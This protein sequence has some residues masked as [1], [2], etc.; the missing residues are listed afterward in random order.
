MI[1]ALCI[2]DL[3]F[4]AE[5]AARLKHVKKNR[6]DRIV[7]ALVRKVLVF[8]PNMDSIPEN[9]ETNPPPRPA[10]IRIIMISNAQAMM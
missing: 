9:P 3:L 10:W 2:M 7:V 8:V 6:I 1:G 4:F 5:K